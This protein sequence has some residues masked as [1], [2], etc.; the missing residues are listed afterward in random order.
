MGV[1]G[2][3]GSIVCP[4]GE[5][6]GLAGR[7]GR[8]RAASASGCLRQHPPLTGHAGR[9]LRGSVQRHGGGRCPP[10][11]PAE[12]YTALRAVRGAGRRGRGGY[13]AAER[14]GRLALAL[15]RHPGTRVRAASGCQVPRPST[16]HTWHAGRLKAAP[17]G[18][19]VRVRDHVE[20]VL[21]VI[22]P[23]GFPDREGK[24]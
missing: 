24:R 6:G 4:P 9:G 7:R 3:C 13:L 17:G 16:R 14:T 12:A 19:G 5:G 1:S 23:A 2:S 21:G 18:S 22:L 20:E 11:V 10:D 15:A 8:G